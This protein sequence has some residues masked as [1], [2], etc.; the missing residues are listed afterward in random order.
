ME[1][2]QYNHV[3]IRFG[4]LSTKGKNKM[5]FIKQL[6][7]NI[8]HA[9]TAFPDLRYER[10]H[11]RLYI[12]LH[13]SDP[14][15]IE[16]RL[17]KVFGISSFSFA[18]KVKSDIEAIRQA[19]LQEAMHSDAKTFKMDTRRHFKMFPMMSDAINRQCASDILQNTNIKVD[20]HHPD[21]RIQVEV[22]EY[23]TYI[24]TKRIKGA[25][26]Y[27]VGTGGKVLVMLSGGIDSPVACYESMKRGLA[28]ECI[29]YAS[30]PY[31]SDEALEKVKDL[32]QQLAL[33]QGSV[34]LHIVPFT[35]MQMV[36]Y[37]HTYESYAITMMRRMMYRMA[38]SLAIKQSCLAIVNGECLGQVA[39]QTLESM[40]V[41]GRVVD[42]PILR[43]LITMD[44]LD[45][46]KIAEQIHTYDISI[47]P[48]E[49]CCTIF[50]PKNPTTKPNLIKVEK[51]EAKFD[52]M[53]EINKAMEQVESIQIY[54]DKKDNDDAIF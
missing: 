17:K 45:I 22:R 23:D 42:L 27:P 30:P 20:V 31:T 50:T 52:Y 33:Y 5:V 34:R 19:V 43:P 53:S 47:R 25:G 38:E 18:I 44:K 6:L 24:M 11:D 28:I 29:H 7:R 35:H 26:G 9:L 8:K 46:I 40:N 10:G 49:D 2:N 14:K 48:F 16:E 21:L 41:I 37:K 12:I 51:Q 15:M 13:G 3:L 1:S 32:A 36:I 54:Y 39:S 4:E